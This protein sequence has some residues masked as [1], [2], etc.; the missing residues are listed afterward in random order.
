MGVQEKL[1][2]LQRLKINAVSMQL[3]QAANRFRTYERKILGIP[4]KPSN[5]TDFFRLK[6]KGWVI[7]VDALHDL[8]LTTHWSKIL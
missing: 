8:D 7:N 1:D 6:P 3:F 5:D 4:E 2:I